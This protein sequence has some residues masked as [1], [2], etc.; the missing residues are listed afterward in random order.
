[1]ELDDSDQDGGDDQKRWSSAPTWKRRKRK[2][3]SQVLI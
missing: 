3:K 2:T 1:M